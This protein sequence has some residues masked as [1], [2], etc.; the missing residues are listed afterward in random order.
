RQVRKCGEQRSIGPARILLVEHRVDDDV[1]LLDRGTITCG[2]AH[3]SGMKRNLM[4]AQDS[5][6][7]LFGLSNQSRHRVACR[8][9]AEGAVVSRKTR[10]AGYEHSHETPVIR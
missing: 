2:L 3:V 5:Q 6:A 1:A 9:Q 8:R 7:R 4:R 10:G